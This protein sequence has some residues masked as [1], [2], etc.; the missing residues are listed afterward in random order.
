MAIRVVTPLA[1][2]ALGDGGE[3]IG[4]ESATWCKKRLNFVGCFTPQRRQ[5]MAVRAH[6]QADLAVT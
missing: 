5:N 1:N 3:H 4:R 6:R 2:S